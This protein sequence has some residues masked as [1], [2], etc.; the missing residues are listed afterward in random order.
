MCP[1]KLDR[2]LSNASACNT[3]FKQLF[4]RFRGFKSETVKTFEWVTMAIDIF[5]PTLTFLLAKQQID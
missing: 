5:N 1:G 3:Q 2:M 4:M